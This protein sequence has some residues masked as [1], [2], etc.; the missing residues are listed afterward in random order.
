MT[1]G[2]L[3]QGA[4]Q[5]SLNTEKVFPVEAQ[6]SIF[7]LLI[8]NLSSRTYRKGYSAA[9]ERTTTHLLLI[10]NLL[11]PDR[12]YRESYSAAS[13]RTTT[14]LLLIRNF[15]APACQAYEPA[16]TGVLLRA[17]KKLL[18]LK[19]TYNFP[20]L[21]YPACAV[22]AAGAHRGLKTYL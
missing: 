5:R 11:A 4:P 18:L 14:H 13:E 2:W 15:L 10:R 12:T 3:L 8:R 17:F 1:P 22:R 16:R 7:N 6:K 19:H 21:T 9:S 20:P